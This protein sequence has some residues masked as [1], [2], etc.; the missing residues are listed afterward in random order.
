MKSLFFLNKCMYVASV[1]IV[2][3]CIIIYIYLC[4][5]LIDL[6]SLPAMLLWV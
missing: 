3:I 5:C 2:Y 4:V 1:C 6:L